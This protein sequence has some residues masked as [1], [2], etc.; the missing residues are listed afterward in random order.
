MIAAYGKYSENYDEMCWFRQSFW[1]EM[2]KT[3]KYFAFNEY[4]LLQ[5][6]TAQNDKLIVNAKFNFDFYGKGFSSSQ[7]D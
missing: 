6:H 4:N 1:S 2:T 3:R 7:T 5:V